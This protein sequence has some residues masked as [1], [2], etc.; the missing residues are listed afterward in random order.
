MLSNATHL[1]RDRTGYE[2]ASEGKQHGCGMCHEKATKI[3]HRGWALARD[4]FRNVEVR[5]ILSIH[6]RVI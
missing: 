2:Q 6:P 5:E 1:S 4:P 3:D